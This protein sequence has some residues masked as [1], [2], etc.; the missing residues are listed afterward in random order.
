MTADLI[1]KHDGFSLIQSIGKVHMVMDQNQMSQKVPI[2]PKV[3]KT[4]LEIGLVG[5]PA[6]FFHF[7]TKTHFLE[8]FVFHQ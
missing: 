2:R 7:R 3:K 5:F 1:T 8:T 4:T 6:S